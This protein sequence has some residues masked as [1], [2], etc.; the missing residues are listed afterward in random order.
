MHRRLPYRTKIEQGDISLQTNQ[1]VAGKFHCGLTYHKMLVL[2]TSTG[3]T[4]TSSQL[5][6]VGRVFTA[7]PTYIIGGDYGNTSSTE[8]L[9]NIVIWAV[10]I[11]QQMVL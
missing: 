8:I 6:A 5:T 9:M 4:A 3:L 10:D 7:K 2:L 11:I 1:Q